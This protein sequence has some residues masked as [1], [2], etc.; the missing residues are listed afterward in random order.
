[1]EKGVLS[2]YVVSVFYLHNIKNQAVDLL[3]LQN[4][5]KSKRLK[6]KLFS[7]YCLGLSH[8]KNHSPTKTFTVCFR[9]L[10]L[11]SGYGKTFTNSYFI[12]S[13]VVSFIKFGRRCVFKVK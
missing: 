3:L 9:C 10:L 2:L 1:M 13:I 5:N 8:F 11:S 7:S 12:P 4:W 6:P